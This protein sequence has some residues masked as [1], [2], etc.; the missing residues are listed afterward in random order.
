M[1]PISA[2]SVPPS[3]VSGQPSRRYTHTRSTGFIRI[4]TGAGR[5]GSNWRHVQV[6]VTCG[7]ALRRSRRVC[8]PAWARSSPVTRMEFGIAY[9]S[10]ARSDRLARGDAPNR[11]TESIPCCLS[12][13]VAPL[14]SRDLSDIGFLSR[15]AS[16]LLLSSIKYSVCRARA[17]VISRIALCTVLRLLDRHRRLPAGLWEAGRTGCQRRRWLQA[18]VPRRD[19]SPSRPDR[20]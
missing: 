8:L 12:C 4:C 19:P 3:R 15:G 1:P 18:A 17:L 10:E 2:W 16:C 5:R 7:G 14:S 6:L 11:W 13:A 20:S 9:T